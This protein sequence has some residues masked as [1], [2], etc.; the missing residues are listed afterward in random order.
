MRS[1]N[2]ADP[3]LQLIVASLVHREALGALKGIK[4]LSKYTEFIYHKTYFFRAP[5]VNG[6]A[7]LF[8][9]LQDSQ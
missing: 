6:P 4:G 7:F 1:C 2:T 8:S 9:I 3:A 5:E